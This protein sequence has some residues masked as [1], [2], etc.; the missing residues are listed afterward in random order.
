ML[1]NPLSTIRPAVIQDYSVVPCQ[2]A[3]T[4]PK[5]HKLPR[6]HA[7]GHKPREVEVLAPLLVVPSYSCRRN[8][9]PIV[10]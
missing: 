3:I 9:A 4:S 7:N 5:L 1:K 2:N 6:G 8:R 10:A